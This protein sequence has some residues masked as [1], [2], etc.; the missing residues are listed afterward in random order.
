[1]WGW[2][3]V[4]AGSRSSE[5]ARTSSPGNGYPFAPQRGNPRSSI[6]RLLGFQLHRVAATDR[7]GYRYREVWFTTP[8]WFITGMAGSLGIACA[9]PLYR[10]RRKARRLHSGLCPRC[11][12]DLRGSKDR[13]PECGTAPAPSA[14]RHDSLSPAG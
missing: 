6:T 4:P 10:R 8:Y 13:C 7:I 2:Y 3:N 1:M 12:Y 11:G 5:F 14:V 9:T